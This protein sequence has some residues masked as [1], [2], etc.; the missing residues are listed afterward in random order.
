MTPTELASLEALAKAATPG[1]WEVIASTRGDW[2][3]LYV[4]GAT[5]EGIVAMVMQGVIKDRFRHNASYIAA[6]NPAAILSLIEERERMREALEPFASL[7]KIILAE[8]PR[9]ASTAV[10]FTGA[11]GEKYAVSLYALRRAA[12]TI[13]ET[14]K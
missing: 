1:D 9:T 5:D 8:A 11:S 12:D 3:S 10:L 2:P 14:S 4:R 7:A 13:Q 6:A